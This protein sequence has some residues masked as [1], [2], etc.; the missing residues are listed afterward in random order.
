MSIAYSYMRFSSPA[1]AE[2]DSIR[3]QVATSEDWCRRNG[4][5]LDEQAT[6]RDL[7]KSAFRGAHRKNPDRN[8]LA[9]FLRLVE[10]GRVARGSYLLLENLDRLSREHI[11]PALSLLLNLIESGVRVVQL[12]PVE[13][14]FGE[15]VE[16]MQ[17]MMAIME[18]SRGNSESRIKSER[19]GAVWGEKKA[20]ARRS[21]KLI[22]QRLPAWLERRGDKLVVVP[23]KVRVVQTIFRLCV[24]GYGLSSIVKHLTAAKIA[25]FGGAK[26]LSKV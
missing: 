25:P 22:T 14:V 12:K 10:E 23:D 24:D 21:G 13:Q 9:A 20:E 4:V 16:P 17:L 5:V 3:R 8:A 26:H 7:G 15:D 1:Q 18:L 11:R 2:G 6:Y 19:M